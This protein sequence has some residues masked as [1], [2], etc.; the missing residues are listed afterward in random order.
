[1]NQNQTEDLLELLAGAGVLNRLTDSSPE[2]WA[3]A[4]ADLDPRDCMRAAGHLI[5]TQQWVKISDIREAIAAARAERIAAANLV[6]D[7]NPGETGAQSADSI[8]ALVDAAA[9]GELPSASIT[10]SLGLDQPAELLSGRA[11]AALAATGR[12]I[13]RQ[14]EGV[15]NVLAVGCPRCFARPGRNCTTGHRRRANVH[16]ARLDD[17]HRAAAGLPPV[18]PADMQRELE[19]R[20]EVTRRALGE[21]AQADDPESEA[22]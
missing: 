19:R 14:R 15:T 21:T 12:S 9:S 11:R 20:R 22:S 13:P 17:A 10:A 5:R 3:A 6:Y 1:M 7:G 16:P 2:V 4:L 18:D 8:R